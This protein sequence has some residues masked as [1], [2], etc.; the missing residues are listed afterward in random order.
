MPESSPIQQSVSYRENGK[1]KDVE[2][3]G[4]RAQVETKLWNQNLLQRL[5]TSPETALG[6]VSF[7]FN[8]F[9]FNFQETM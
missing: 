1:K 6:E 3:E 9:N 4:R 8:Q 5:F 2:M 7:H